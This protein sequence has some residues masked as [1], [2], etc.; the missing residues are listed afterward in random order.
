MKKF[1][2]QD[3]IALI[4]SSVTALLIAALFILLYIVIQETVS[5][6]LDADLDA[7]TQEVY[8]SIVVLDNTLIFANPNEW[9]EREHG[10]IQVNPTFIEIVDS[11]GRVMK[12][13]PNLHDGALTFNP[14]LTERTYIDTQLSETA[15]RQIQFPMT[16]PTGRIIAYLL[17]AIPQQ[18][19]LLLLKNLRQ[20]LLI[21]YPLV[22][23]VLFFISRIIAARS[24]SP[25]NAVITTAE[26]ISKEN[27]TDRI[28]LPANKDVLYT[29][30]QTI[31]ALLDRL[32]EV[33]LR[34]KQFTA[35][36]SHE[37]RTPLSVI[38]GTLEVLIRKPREREQYEAKIRYVV[39][40]V[41][42]M[43]QLVDQLLE[44]ARF[45]SLAI[46][47]ASTDI[48]LCAEV[49]ES[50]RRLSTAARA[51]NIAFR[52]TPAEHSHVHADCSMMNIIFDN[53]LSN[54]I[55]YSPDNESIDVKIRNSSGATECSITD[56][57]SG[58]PEDQLAKIFDRFYRVDESRTS[59]IAGKGLGLAIVKRLADLQNLKISV[60]SSPSD[61]TTFTIIFPEDQRV[62]STQSIDPLMY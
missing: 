41:D 15:I 17:I 56:H 38:K 47:P 12:K 51:K 2:L 58:I 35:D 11:T 1:N 23:I 30:A 3:R 31:N 6:H 33:V 20:T 54:A 18:E 19:P 26:K 9:A 59:H 60:I 7:E 29:L 28:E 21:G 32:Q 55:K 49:N 50:F 34:E 53:I 61:G 46:R 62:D 37:L 40:E 48:D 36:A 57:G 52:I 39:T 13:T 24:L 22:L 4:Y 45:E 25:I 27:L 16:N 14:A 42:R 5:T 43:S 44:L 10:Q 8:S